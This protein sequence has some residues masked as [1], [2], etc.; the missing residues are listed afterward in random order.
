MEPVRGKNEMFKKS[1]ATMDKQHRRRYRKRRTEMKKKVVEEKKL[2]KKVER[3]EPVGGA[4][5]TCRRQVDSQDDLDQIL[6]TT[7]SFDQILGTRKIF[8]HVIFR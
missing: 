8:V 7:K 4:L 3:Q 6:G 2:R 1:L 5:E